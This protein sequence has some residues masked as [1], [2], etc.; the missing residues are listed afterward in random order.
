MAVIAKFCMLPEMNHVDM[1]LGGIWLSLTRVSVCKKY[2][3]L[4]VQ[5]SG[6]ELVG[7]YVEKIEVD[8]GEFVS[9]Y[10]LGVYVS[11]GDRSITHQSR[12]RELFTS[13]KGFINNP[14]FRDVVVYM[15]V[16]VGSDAVKGGVHYRT[17]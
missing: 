13:S 10:P 1:N 5:L 9:E 4:K 8:D 7:T 12:P 16:L 11:K 3:V 15:R 2:S 17:G 6:S 14:T